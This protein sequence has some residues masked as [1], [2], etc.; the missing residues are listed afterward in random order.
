MLSTSEQEQTSN[1]VRPVDQHWR[2]VQFVDAGPHWECYYKSKAEVETSQVASLDMT[3]QR[4]RDM[5]EGLVDGRKLAQT[6]SST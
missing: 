3:W 2:K 5:D 6:S 4:G 1:G